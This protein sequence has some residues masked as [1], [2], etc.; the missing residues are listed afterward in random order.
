MEA[1]DCAAPPSPHAVPWGVEAALQGGS[2]LPSNLGEG[3][4]RDVGEPEIKLNG[5]R[6]ELL[7]QL[8]NTAE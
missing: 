1:D 2:L 6:T 8:W 5:L 7:R 4:S 3:R